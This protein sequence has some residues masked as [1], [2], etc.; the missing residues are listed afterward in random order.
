V[1]FN[2]QGPVAGAAAEHRSA[3]LCLAIPLLPS[4]SEYDHRGQAR[5][6]EHEQ[7]R[8]FP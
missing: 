3:D 4:D 7:G 1:I 5:L 2:P 8:E 6:P